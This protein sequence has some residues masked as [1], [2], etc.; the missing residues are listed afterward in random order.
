M[1]DIMRA[2]KEQNNENGYT[3]SRTPE[4]GVNEG[5]KAW[6]TRAPH[7][8]SGH[9]ENYNQNPWFLGGMHRFYVS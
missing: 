4:A 1:E 8:W 2:Y 9:A 6:E 7:N 5:L 3:N